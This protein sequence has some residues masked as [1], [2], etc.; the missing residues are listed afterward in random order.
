MCAKSGNS[1]RVTLMTL[2]QTAAHFK[3][4]FLNLQCMQNADTVQRAACAVQW[5]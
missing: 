5:R 2:A 1:F 3:L 4:T